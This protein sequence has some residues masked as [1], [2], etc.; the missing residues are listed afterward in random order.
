MKAKKY[1]RKRKKT[2]NFLLISKKIIKILKAIK[3]TTKIKY[4]RTKHK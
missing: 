3:E 4:I 1:K 2:K